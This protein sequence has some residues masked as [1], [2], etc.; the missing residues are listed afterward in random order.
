MK[1]FSATDAKN[2]FGDLLDSANLEPIVISKNG[3]EIA[4]MMSKA[5]FEKLNQSVSRKELIK[6][7]HEESMERYGGVYETLAK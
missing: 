3:R 7:L 2:R 1:H 6:R 4:V 5:E